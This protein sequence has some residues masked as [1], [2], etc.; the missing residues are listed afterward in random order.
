MSTV[1]E[2]GEKLTAAIDK[3]LAAGGK[4][5]RGLWG[6]YEDGT[7]HMAC[8]KAACVLGVY[9]SQEALGMDLSQLNINLD[10]C[11]W[12]D[13]LA[14]EF[15]GI[16]AE[17]V[18]DIIQGFDE[19]DTRNEWQALGDELGEKYLGPMVRDPDDDLY[20]EDY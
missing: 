19:G 4:L 13:K 5:E 14:A 12:R 15:L 9:L 2:V 3:Y 8:G 6:V 20:D 7:Q 17:Q 1:E 16:T 10:F 11:G 18:A